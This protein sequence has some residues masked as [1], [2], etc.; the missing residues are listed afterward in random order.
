MQAW[1]VLLAASALHIALGYRMLCK[2]KI[3]EI[4]AR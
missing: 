1:S 2:K 4:F 3:V